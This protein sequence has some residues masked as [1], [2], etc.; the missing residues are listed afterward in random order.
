ML[1][2]QETSQLISEQRTKTLGWSVA[3]IEEHRRVLVLFLIISFKTQS[4]AL[5]FG[6]TLAF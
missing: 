4:Q 6:Q 3:A 1:K 2:P 5:Y